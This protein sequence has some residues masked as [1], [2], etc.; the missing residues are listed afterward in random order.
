MRVSTHVRSRRSHHWQG[1]PSG[2]DARAPSIV[3]FAARISTSGLGRLPPVALPNSGHFGVRLLSKSATVWT[4]PKP[5]DWVLEKQTFNAAAKLPPRSVAT[6]ESA[7]PAC[8]R[9]A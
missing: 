8:R 7:S 9:S 6:R 5:V 1:Q 4:R 2:L 3:R